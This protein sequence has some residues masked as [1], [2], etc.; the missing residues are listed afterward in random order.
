MRGCRSTLWHEGTA[1]EITFAVVHR[2][3]GD[4]F[5]AT[6]SLVLVLLFF[7]EHSWQEANFLRVAAAVA[8][9]AGYTVFS[10]WL[11]SEVCGSW[12]YTDQVSVVPFLDTCFS[13][14]A[15]WL[16]I[17]PAAFWWAHRSTGRYLPRAPP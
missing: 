12:A 7:A 4:L 16:A 6:A 13:R 2:T 8:F 3:G 10:E 1:G 5:I 15:K 11:T 14:L 9:G 17:P